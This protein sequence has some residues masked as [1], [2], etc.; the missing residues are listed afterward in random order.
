MFKDLKCKGWFIFQSANIQRLMWLIFHSTSRTQSWLYRLLHDRQPPNAP[1]S[2]QIL[3]RS[4]V[5]W[6]HFSSLCELKMSLCAEHLSYGFIWDV[7]QQKSSFTVSKQWPQHPST[8]FVHLPERE[9]ED[10]TP[11]LAVS[12]TRR[13]KQ[14]T[15]TCRGQDSVSQK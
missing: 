12:K 5:R 7:M 2:V 11:S 10:E 15:E 6:Y 9:A 8:Q 1:W 4:P 13:H 3:Q 14:T